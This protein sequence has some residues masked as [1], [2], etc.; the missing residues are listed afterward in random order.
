[1][2]PIVDGL[3]GEYGKRMTFRALD[4]NGA[5]KAL[6]QQFRL[7]GHPAYVVL[8][9]RGQV[10]WQSVGQVAREVLEAAIQRALP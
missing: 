6:F 9:A 2:R 5:G 8:D 10:V 4:V 7:R 1:M 3:Q